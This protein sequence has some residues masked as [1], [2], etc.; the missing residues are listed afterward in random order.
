M[1]CPLINKEMEVVV[2]FLD[3]DYD[4]AA[5]LEG[6]T[7]GLEL[8]LRSAFS[9]SLFSLPLVSSAKTIWEISHLLAR[10]ARASTGGWDSRQRTSG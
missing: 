6:G 10:G 4:N 2:F 1:L 8:P 3:I 5:W 9:P 7:P